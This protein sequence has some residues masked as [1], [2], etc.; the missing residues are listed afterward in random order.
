VSA[1]T[2]LVTGAASGIGRATAIELA[3]RGYR[4]GVNH[5]GRAQEASAV[6]DEIGGLAVEADVADTRAVASAVGRIERELGPIDVAVCCAGFDEDRPLEETGDAHWDRSLRVI[7]GGCVNVMAAVAPAMKTRGRGSIVTISSELALAGDRDHV[8]YVTA[9]AAILGLTRAMAHELAPFG[10]RVNSI[11]PGPTD[12]ALLGERWRVNE[13]IERIPLRRLGTAEELAA[14]I[15][16]LAE[17]T[18]TTGQVLSP[19]GGIVIQ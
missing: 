9:K 14:S 11:A 5:L 12:T 10:I 2:A 8:G 16:G 4:V 13:Y 1:P 7:L 19:N 15:V 18:W 6:A 17:A 3:K